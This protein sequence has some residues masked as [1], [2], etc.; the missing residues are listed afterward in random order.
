MAAGCFPAAC[1]QGGLLP[2]NGRQ[3]KPPASTA[4]S[5]RA[6]G[7]TLVPHPGAL[8]L[9]HDCA[10]EMPGACGMLSAGDAPRDMGMGL[11]R[12]RAA[13]RRRRR[14]ATPGLAL[15]ALA[16]AAA[17]PASETAPPALAPLPRPAVQPAEPV[18]PAAAAALFAIPAI[19]DETRAALAAVAPDDLAAAAAALDALI[20]RHPGVGSVYANRAALAMLE[21]DPAAALDLL[22]AAARHGFA[23][24]PGLAADPLF[25]PLGPE[26][27]LAALVAAA[28]VPVALPVKGGLARVEATN[29]AW[30]PATER[31]EPRF[32][33]AAEPAGGP[34][35][36]A[37]GNAA[38]DI[39][40]DLWTKGRAAGNHGD[41]YD[42]RDRGHSRLDPADHPQLS[43]VAYAGAARAADLDYGLNER[44]LF[45]RP[46]IGNS[47]TAITGG[48][49]WRSLP[50]AAMTRPDGT[51]PFRLWQNAAANHLYVYPAH[52]DF[53]DEDGDLFPANT[54]YILVSRGSSGSDRRFLGALA[55]IYAGFQPETKQ[56]LESEHL[57]VPTVQM[58]FRRSLQTVT[59]REAYLSGDAHPAA[60]AGFE[61]NPARMVRLANSI[62][63]DA[64]PP[65]VRIRVTAEE[66]GTEGR[67][68]FGIGLSEQ[69]FDTPSAVA[70]IWRSRAGRRV[71]EVSAEETADPN[72]RELA[73]AWRLLQGDPERVRIEPLDDGRRARITLDWHDPFPISDDNPL[74]TARVDIGVF[75]N[76]GVHDSA[77]AI[78]SWYF[79]PS[80]ARSYAP[81]PDGAPRIAS[82][83]YAGRKAYADPMLVA[84]AD[85]RDDYH[86]APDGSLL[87]WTRVR[88][89]RRE[90]F[91]AA[92]ARILAPAEGPAPART[93]PV[94]YPLRRLPDGRLGIAEVSAGF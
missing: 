30:N 48:A 83:D 2:Q 17:A 14:W 39:L 84:R 86:W 65:E 57:L 36:Q 59:S 16:L 77:P 8:S 63:P 31:L 69:L 28:P 33:F 93:E 27:R 13:G 64:I 43:H 60:F 24:I 26:P 53:T 66:L 42:N 51:G 71:I 54:P 62:D 50:R 74:V 49:L 67:D 90:E 73:F 25:A 91:D 88:G 5:L 78:L 19:A 4:R 45:D 15:L 21:G 3:G 9:G 44:L 34:V 52:K 89:E 56:R 68:F 12:L 92:G 38:R 82:I 75:A 70:R 41:L 81:G 11:S 18:D 20:A 72:G 94:A 58:V 79:P 7:N 80:E 32:A 35:P 22:E 46:T 29:T 37:R 85:W 1:G 76:N 10:S 55:L 61:I 23:G 47:S 40:D 6:P 87:G